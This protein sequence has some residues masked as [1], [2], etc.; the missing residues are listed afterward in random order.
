MN[1]NRRLFL[2]GL[3]TIP[4]AACNQAQSITQP[5]PVSQSTGGGTTS[6]RYIVSGVADR[7]MTLRE[8]IQPHNPTLTFKTL[9]NDYFVEGF[10][11]TRYNRIVFLI[12]DQQFSDLGISRK[13]LEPGQRWGAIQA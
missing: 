9:E 3:A 1:L 8:A 5:T 11:G 4:I 7:R 6:I 13:M 10:N 2:I 12:N